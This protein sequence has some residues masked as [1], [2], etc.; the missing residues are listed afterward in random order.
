MKKHLN[1]YRHIC[2]ILLLTGAIIVLYTSVLGKLFQ[3]ITEHVHFFHLML[4]LLIGGYYIKELNARQTNQLF[5]PFQFHVF[6]MLV[7]LGATIAFLLTSVFIGVNT[8]SNICFMITAYGILTFY[9]PQQS[10]KKNLIPLLLII[11]I[12]PSFNLIGT[13][14]DVYLGF[15]LRILMAKWIA[16]FA[17]VMGAEYANSSTILFIENQAMQI[18][19]QCSGVR[20]LWYG[21]LFFGAMIWIEAKKS[22]W[23]WICMFFLLT[24]ALLLGNIARVFLIVCLHAVLELPE[25][26]AFVHQPMGIIAFILSCVWV[27]WMVD[28]WPKA[29]PKEGILINGREE[30]DQ[31]ILNLEGTTETHHSTSQSWYH[32]GGLI[33]LVSAMVLV[34]V[35]EK[36]M[37]EFVP[38]VLPQISMFEGD[39]LANGIAIEPVELTKQE[40]QF[41]LETKCPAY[42][43]TFN[44]NDLSGSFLMAG[45][46]N[47]KSHHLPRLCIQASGHSIKNEHTYLLDSS[48]PVRWLDLMEAQYT[49][50]YWFQHESRITE[51]YADRIWAEISGT[52]KG[53]VMVS[54]LFKGNVKEEDK[55]VAKV[56][57]QIKESVG[58]W[59]TEH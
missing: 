31:V 22:I 4:I 26:A 57:Y 30:T 58:Q 49:A 43:F 5:Q 8:L 52:S 27:W 20:S 35:I 53:W 34:S 47:W 9:T 1:R 28:Q 42:K 39:S 32:W 21:W 12:L 25:M 40:Q 44:T 19:V 55:E 18:D 6:G 16:S 37:T 38:K 50:C 17:G 13:L 14:I 10:W 23:V 3:S 2:S 48:F 33:G 56:M 11:M 29:E 54:L 15:P 46:G 24:M 41:F 45:K 51:D 59:I 7:V 36:S